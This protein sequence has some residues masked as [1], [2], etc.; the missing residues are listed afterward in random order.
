MK[1]QNK[2]PE[3][4]LKREFLEYNTRQKHLKLKPLSYDEYLATVYGKV[5]LKKEFKDLKYSLP[6]TDCVQ[7][8]VILVDHQPVR[9]SM[10]EKALQGKLSETDTELVVA[11]SNRIGL[12]T[13]KG[14]Y[15]YIT[16]E[17]DLKTL[18]KKT[19]SL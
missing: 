2:V 11:K 9:N 14:G 1:K 8:A 13:A 6:V 16:D 19:Q 3:K 5:K 17:T 7:T 15:S 10:M 12:S 18:G 4:Q